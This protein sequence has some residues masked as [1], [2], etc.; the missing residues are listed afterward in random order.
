MVESPEMYAVCSRWILALPESDVKAV[1]MASPMNEVVR[2][3]CP[4]PEGEGL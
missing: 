1:W 2:A 3:Y 4:S